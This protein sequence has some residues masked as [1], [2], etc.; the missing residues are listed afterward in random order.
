V[1]DIIV[2]VDNTARCARRVEF[3]AA[4]AARFGGQLAG[5]Y[6]HDVAVIPPDEGLVEDLGAA[7]APERIGY[8]AQVTRVEAEAAEQILRAGSARLKT[9]TAWH[10]MVGG[11]AD[12]LVAY[13]RYADLVVVGQTPPGGDDVAA[14]VALRSGR[15]VLIAPHTP[16][17]RLTAE[18]ILVAWD[19]SREAA[20]AMHDALPLLRNAR[21]VTVLSVGNLEKAPPGADV[22][23]HLAHHGVKIE[24]VQAHD[25]QTN[26]GDFILERAQKLSCD[27]IVMGAYGHSPWRQRVLGGTTLHVLKRVT[28]P[29]LVAH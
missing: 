15:P 9:S 26:A 5:V 16:D 7:S 4:L 17:Y 10:T 8:D 11:D 19:A 3:A 2:H 13:A 20:R 21:R 27:L 18:R 25:V 1:K 28:M 23:T 6:A 24:L 12:V 29:V 22:G 14:E